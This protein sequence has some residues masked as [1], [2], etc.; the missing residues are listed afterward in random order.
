MTGS[1]SALLSPSGRVLATYVR[2]ERDGRPL[3]ELLRPEAGVAVDE[4]VAAV[5]AELPGWIVGSEFAL[6]DALLAAGCTPRRRGVVM[7]RDLTAAEIPAPPGIAIV[8]LAHTAAEL[9]EASLRAFPPG[10]LDRTP[11]STDD[12]ELADLDRLLRGAEVGPVR[13]ESRVALTT[14]GAV[15]GAAIVTDRA[16]EPP[17]DGPW[18]AWVFRDPT[19]TPPGTGA[20]LIAAVIAELRPAGA[21][22]LGLV[23]TAGNPAQRSYERLGFTVALE[24]M[25][26]IVPGTDTTA[27]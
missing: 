16:D 20:A 21:P 7:L 12:E 6:G 23:V 22:Q 13:P 8:P 11:G 14:A 27:A 10:H 9:H 19:T 5:L 26:V 1:R 3:A 15:A 18:L 2:D 25:T 24:G 17:F 4:L